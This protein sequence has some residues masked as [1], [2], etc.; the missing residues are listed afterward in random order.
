MDVGVNGSS[1]WCDAVYNSSVDDQSYGRSYGNFYR[2]KLGG[3]WDDGSG[4]GSRSV[5]VDPWSAGVG[6][7]RGGRGACEPKNC[8]INFN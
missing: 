5:A 3:R 1:G 2:A 7:D 6:S 8:E 4:C